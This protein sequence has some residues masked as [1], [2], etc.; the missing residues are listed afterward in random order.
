MSEPSTSPFRVVQ[1][2]LVSAAFAHRGLPLALAHSTPIP[3]QRIRVEIALDHLDGGLATQVRVAVSSISEPDDEP[4]FYDFRVEVAAIVDQVDR[5]AFPDF[6]LAEV[7]AAMVFPF[8]R[9]AV[10]NISGRGRF[11]PIWLN[12]FDIHGLLQS[13]RQHTESKATEAREN[14]ENKTPTS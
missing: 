2:Y 4:A 12:P 1:I 14:E 9:E 13:A 8:V 11:G 10:A 7:A 5:V 6:E 3:P